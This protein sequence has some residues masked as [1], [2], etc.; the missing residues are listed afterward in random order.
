MTEQELN[1]MMAEAAA[2]ARRNT[3]NS[4]DEWKAELERASK[5]SPQQLLRE[6]A[7]SV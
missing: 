1:T 6:F 4:R 3:E 2:Q 5:L 7:D